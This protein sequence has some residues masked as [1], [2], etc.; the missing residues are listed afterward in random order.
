MSLI[1]RGC[2]AGSDP[3]KHSIKHSWDRPTHSRKSEWSRCSIITRDYSD[4]PMRLP[5]FRGNDGQNMRD[6]RREAER[7]EE[8][9]KK[10]KKERK[11]ERD[12]VRKR[13]KI[14]T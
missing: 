8:E 9:E 2:T 10:K 3:V 11:T 6:G 14:K 4:N 5:P 1:A 7:R 12:K 13:A